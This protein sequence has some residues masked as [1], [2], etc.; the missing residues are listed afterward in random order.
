MRCIEICSAFEA[1]FM[2]K[3]YIDFGV[4]C[5]SDLIAQTH[6]KTTANVFKN[7]YLCRSTCHAQYFCAKRSPS[8]QRSSSALWFTNS[9]YA[10]SANSVDD[11]HV[12]WWRRRDGLTKALALPRNPHRNPSWSHTTRLSPRPDA[13]GDYVL[14]SSLFG[15]GK[16]GRGLV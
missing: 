5:F 14:D 3:K 16:E 4:T 1:H 7:G 9:K 12:L 13:G 10:I 8:P 6:F 2:Y 15:A 11:G